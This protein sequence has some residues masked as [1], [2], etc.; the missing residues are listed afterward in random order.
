MKLNVLFVGDNHISARTPANRKDN[1]LEATLN[2]LK[3]CLEL[4]V[5]HKVDAI[6]LLG[7]VFDTREEG[8]LARNGALNI[9]KSQPDGVP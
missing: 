9:L 1:Y 5:K 6:V 2:K 3:D 4:G 8:P 7:D